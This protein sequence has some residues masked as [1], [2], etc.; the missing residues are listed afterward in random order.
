MDDC[1]EISDDEE[2]IQL[3]KH[4]VNLEPIVIDLTNCDQASQNNT[5]DTTNQ[6]Q[7]TCSQNNHSQFNH[8]DSSTQNAQPSPQSDKQSDIESEPEPY[9]DFEP[10]LRPEPDFEP[11]PDLEQEPQHETQQEREQGARLEPE[12]ELPRVPEQEPDHRPKQQLNNKVPSQPEPNRVASPQVEPKSTI[13][14]D[15]QTRPQHFKRPQ[16]SDHELLLLQKDQGNEKYH[17]NRFDDAIRIYRQAVGLAKKLD[18]KEMS[19]IL[20]FNLAMTY[21]K[22]KYYDQAA[23]E[24]AN[25][26]KINNNYLKAHKKRAEIYARQNKLDEAVICYEYLSEL[27]SDNHHIYNHFMTQAK[28]AKESNRWVKKKDY[29]QILG[30]GH[31]CT[32]EDLKKAYRKQALNHHPDRHSNADIVTRRIEELR[33][34]EASEAYSFIQRRFAN[35]R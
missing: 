28:Q 5:G 30:L 13:Q 23:D 17:N 4:I 9:S 14:T 26:V 21:D 32:Q 22:L 11:E 2:D 12:K 15:E 33:F 8:K 27:D 24:C 10:E 35:H 31:D 20:H 1:I 25:A 16:M 6:Y 7:N 34:K 29:H 19:A 3:L 18:N